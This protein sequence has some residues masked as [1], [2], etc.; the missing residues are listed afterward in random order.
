M[1]SMYT[2]GR[3]AR[4][5]VRLLSSCHSQ[6]SKKEINI[7]IKNKK[8]CKNKTKTQKHHSKLVLSFN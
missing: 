1:Y 7:K 3:T 4:A 2:K 6:Q 8:N 5:A